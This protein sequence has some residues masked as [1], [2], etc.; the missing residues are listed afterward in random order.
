MTCHDSR[1]LSL[2]L[3]AVLVLACGCGSGD[4]GTPSGGGTPAPSS[5]A[6]SGDRPSNSA[7]A[8]AGAADAAGRDAATD[9]EIATGSWGTLR[10]RFVYD[11]DPPERTKAL[12]NKDTDVCG[13]FDLRDEQLIVAGGGGLADVVIWLHTAGAPIHEEY[14]ATAN[15]TVELDNNQCHFVPH[16]VALRLGQTLHIKNSDPVGHNTQ[17]QFASNHGFNEAVPVGGSKDI[18]P[19]KVERHPVDVVCSIH[20]WMRAN[21]VVKDTPYVAVSAA[22]GAFEIANLP[23]GVELEFQ[24]FHSKSKQVTEV[25]KGGKATA[26]RRGRFSMK[27]A[28]GDNDLGDLLVSPQQFQ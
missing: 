22:D 17:I 9:T 12:V 26:W 23:T 1:Y 27:I 10:G 25:T 24:V 11:G 20:P 15:A 14:T 19:A 4:S 16:V 8:D 18:T 2:Q 28:E 3:A 7:A 13:A 21:L 6:G 5:S